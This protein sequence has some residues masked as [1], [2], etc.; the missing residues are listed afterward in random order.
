MK[1]IIYYPANADSQ[2]VAGARIARWL[3][4]RMKGTMIDSKTVR[5]FVSTSRDPYNLYIINVPKPMV[6]H[7]LDAEK[8]ITGAKTLVWVQNDYA[9]QT[10]T[11]TT[12]GASIFTKAFTW[13]AQHPKTAPMWV[14]TSCEDRV[15]HIPTMA[16]YI[17]WNALAAEDALEPKPYKHEKLLYWGAYRPGRHKSFSRYISGVLDNQVLAD[18]VVISATKNGA[19][20][21][22][23]KLGTPPQCFVGPIFVPDDIQGYA[24][25][26]YMEDEMSHKRFHSPANR[27]YEAL[28]AGVPIMIDVAAVGTLQKA[29]FVVPPEM[30]AG[31]LRDVLG[32]LAKGRRYLTQLRQKQVQKWGVDPATGK[33]HGDALWARVKQ[34]QKECKL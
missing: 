34:L 18:N 24:L 7:V 12:A 15:N 16:R 11:P 31:S 23:E 32:V 10:P 21:F 1:N 2:I 9:I 30:I 13:R 8:V 25:T 22:T 29:G 27:F 28:A 26:L 3:C 14:W 4:E 20:R 33:A 5:E 6:A 19:T 17:N